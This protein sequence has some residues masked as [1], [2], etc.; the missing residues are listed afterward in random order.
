MKHFGGPEGRK[1][2]RGGEKEG[3]QKKERGQTA[4]RPCDKKLKKVLTGGKEEDGDRSHEE[5]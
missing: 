5:G 2:W 1:F 4:N 3:S